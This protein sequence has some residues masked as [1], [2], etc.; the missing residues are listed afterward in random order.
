MSLKYII[1]EIMTNIVK[2]MFFGPLDVN[3]VFIPH[4][5]WN[6]TPHPLDANATSIEIIRHSHWTHTPPF[7]CIRLVH[8]KCMLLNVIYDHS[9]KIF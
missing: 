8:W 2:Q 9:N 3:V 5:H 1:N 4:P 6:Y 7:G